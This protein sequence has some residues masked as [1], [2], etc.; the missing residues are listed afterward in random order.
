MGYDEATYEREKMS[1]SFREHIEDPERFVI[2]L[3]LVPGAETRGRTLD[4]VKGIAAEA[5]ADGR[6]S[7]VTITDNP[8]GNPSLSP[9]GIGKEILES[10]GRRQHLP[11]HEPGRDRSRAPVSTD[12]E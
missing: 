6:V 10:D 1:H 11:G 4:T 5:L 3:E 7:A 9:D 8:G 12:G 2:T